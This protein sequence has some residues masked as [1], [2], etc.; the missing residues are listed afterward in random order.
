M[1]LII[2]IDTEED[3][4]DWRPEMLA[5]VRNISRLPELQSFFNR[6]L[7]IPTYLVDWPV[8]AANDSLKIIRQLVETENC[9]IGA[10]LHSWNTPPLSDDENR[11]AATYLS[12]MPL[13][14]KKEKLYNFTNF[15]KKQLKF[16]P[17]SYRAGRYGFCVQTANFL[18]ELGYTVDTS[19][20]PL[21]DLESDGGPNFRQYNLKPFWIKNVGQ[22]ALLEV[23]VTIGL[24]HRFSRH[25]QN[26]YFQIPEWSK[27]KGVMHRL[28]LARLLWLRPTTYSVNE[29]KQIADYALDRLN[30]PV[31]NIMFHSSELYPGA[32]PYN[33]TQKDVEGFYER[34]GAI[35]S[36]LIKERNL[37]SITLS[38]FAEVCLKQKGMKISEKSFQEE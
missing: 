29:M 2:S 18:K 20:A 24:I 28:N 22:S 7:A 17:T 32:S 34:L 6:H 25:F 15:F 16:P 21:N 4:P 27:I 33:R 30:A 31:L 19:I 38:D 8:I 10:H 14:L 26:I 13:E 36:Y 5:T 3:M 37:K 9:E 23:P 11:G 12:G 35:L 1:Y